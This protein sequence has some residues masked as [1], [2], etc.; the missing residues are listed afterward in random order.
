MW[1]AKS[2]I[3]RP[4]AETM[5]R[6]SP[7]V[8]TGAGMLE[9]R[10]VRITSPIHSTVVDASRARGVGHATP[11]GW[12]RESVAQDDWLCTLFLQCSGP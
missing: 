10:G 9:A 11:R 2:S 6:S 4:T 3:F 12:N 8:S 1:C 5:R 7:S